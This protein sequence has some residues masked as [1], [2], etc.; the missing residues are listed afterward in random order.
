MNFNFKLLDE[1]ITI[2]DSTIFVIEDVRVFANVAKLFYQYDET[3]ELKVFNTKQHPLKSSELMLV[4][5]ILGHDINSA[6]TLKLIYADLE[7]QLNEKPE[8]KSMIDKLTATISELIGYELLEHELD[9][10]EDEI[11]VIELFKALGIKI[12]TKSDTIFEKLIEI[13]QVY[14]YLSKKKLLVFI[15][16]CAYL[17]KEEL[18]ELRRYISLYQVKVLFIE[19][20]KIDGFPQAILDPDY[21]LHV[22]NC[23]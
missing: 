21:F 22:E 1:P 15:N 16:V 11:T 14:K 18:L 9:L 3:G 5:D 19:P 4:T 20:R 17:T 23:V 2:E 7:Q 10:E 12:E 13:V 6:A 8:V